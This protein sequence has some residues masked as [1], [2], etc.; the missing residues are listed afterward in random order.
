MN[1]YLNKGIKLIKKIIKTNQKAINETT[2]LM[3]KTH[4]NK[5]KIFIFGSGHSHLLATEAFYRAGGLTNVQ[6]IYIEPLMMHQGALLSS[7]CEREN[8]FVNKYLNKYTITNKDILIV[9][10]T[11]GKNPA[12]IDVALWAKKVKAQVIVITSPSLSKKAT[13]LHTSKKFLKDFGDI[14][15]DNLIP[16]GDIAL[17]YQDYNFGSYST[18]IGIGLMQ[19]LVTE[20]IKKIIDQGYKAEIWASGNTLDGPK[21]NQRYLAYWKKQIPFL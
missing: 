7:K 11:S 19:I 18:F 5:N 3:A 12:P 21:N 6:P 8:H 17:T 14:V 4:I 2:D 13:S 15:I 20:T 9:I 1:N 16:F 10:S